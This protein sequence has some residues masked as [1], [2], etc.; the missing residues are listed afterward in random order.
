MTLTELDA[1]RAYCRLLNRRRVA[2]IEP[3]LADDFVYKRQLVAAPLTSR[4]DFLRYI[5]AKFATL[6]RTNSPAWGEVGRVR[7]GR[8]LRPCA[9]LAQPTKRDLVGVALATVAGDRIVR[10]DVCIVP[11]AREAERTGEYPGDAGEVICHG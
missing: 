7:V 10:I 1:I 3:L 4:A 2:A 5:E 9:V 11:S 6:L 8:L